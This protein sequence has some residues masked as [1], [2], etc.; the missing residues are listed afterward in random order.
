MKKA[1][2][3]IIN[4]VWIIFIMDW[5]IFGIRLLDHNYSAATAAYIGLACLL[6]IAVY[7]VSMRSAAR[8]PHC[9]KMQMVNG[10]CC[11]HCGK[12]V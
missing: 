12:E 5:G 9:G 3:W 8:C 2:K 11:P 4:A 10:K 1:V 6:L 7:R